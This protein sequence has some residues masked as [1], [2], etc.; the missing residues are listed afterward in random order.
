M[1]PAYAVPAWSTALGTPW[2]PKTRTLPTFPPLVPISI[3]NNNRLWK[4]L[5]LSNGWRLPDDVDTAT[6]DIVAKLNDKAKV[7]ATPG[8]GSGGWKAWFISALVER[9]LDGKTE[10]ELVAADD[11]H[12]QHTKKNKKNKRGYNGEVGEEEYA[13][14]YFDNSKVQMASRQVVV[15]LP[16]GLNGEPEGEVLTWSLPFFGHCVSLNS[17]GGG[18]LL[19]CGDHRDCRGAPCGAS[20]TSC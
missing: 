4:A 17:P 19:P 11:D 7:K 8:T 1:L 12:H 5:A 9:V 18:C 3:N 2:P 16:M 10:R 6:R 20:S 15:S 13:T 14:L